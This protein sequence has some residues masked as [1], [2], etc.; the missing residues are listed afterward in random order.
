MT[1]RK[2][3]VWKTIMLVDRMDYRNME[4][5]WGSSHGSFGKNKVMNFDGVA[6]IETNISLSGLRTLARHAGVRID[7]K[8]GILWDSKPLSEIEE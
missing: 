7:W 8:N 5:A 1:N 4:S 2:R 3:L 6:G